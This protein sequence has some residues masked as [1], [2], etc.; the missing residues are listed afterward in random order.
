MRLTFTILLFFFGIQVFAQSV[1]K[2]RIISDKTREPLAYAE[3]LVNN[4]RQI[5]TNIDGSFHFEIAGNS[6]E[7]QVSYIGYQSIKTEVYSA[8]KFV[9]FS[10][11]PNAEMLDEVMIGDEANP[12]NAIIKRAIVARDQNDPEKVL[13]HFQYKSYTKFIIDNENG[14]IQMVSDSTSRNIRTIINEGRGYLSEKVAEH[15]YSKDGGSQEEVIG[16]E[17][18]GFEKPVYN[19][20]SLNI[21]P[22]SLYKNK[23]SL[24][25]TDYAG[26]LANDALRNYSY[27]IL[28]TTKSKRPAYMIYFKPKRHQIVA[29]L[30]GILYLDM[31]TLA[32]QKAKAQ[33]LGAIKLEINH[34]YQYYQ[35]LD[36]WFPS[37]QNT[38]IR[39]G[40]GGKEIAVF[41]GTI[42]VGMVQQKK[43][44][45][46]V[47]SKPKTISN[48]IYLNSSTTNFDI[49]LKPADYFKTH[50]A[51][52]LVANGAA[53]QPEEFWEKNRKEDFTSR[54]QA[55][56]MKVDSLLQAGNVKR[57][58][59]VKNAIATG[60][61]P[62]GF[63][64]ADLSKV[65][66]FNNYEGIRLGFG[67]KTSD[68]V[69]EK[70]NINGYTTYGFKDQVVKYGI[71][72]QVYLKKRTN[73]S[74]NFFYSRDIEETGTFD[75]LK[76]TN[77]FS[78]L[79]PRFV[80]INFFY[81]YKTA[82]ASLKHDII[83]SL[84]TEFRLG[85]QEIWQIKN[86]RYQDDNQIYQD[87]DLGTMTF[88]F[89]WRPF[90][91]FLSTPENT[92]MIE[93]NFPQFTGQIE[94]S[95]K[96][97][98][99]GDFEFTRVGLKA[100]HEINQLDRSRTEFILEGNMAFGDVPLTHAFHSYPNNPNR[101]QIFRRF[102]VAGRNSFETMYFNEFFSDRQA[103]LH[104][105]HQLRPF[106]I[107]EKFQPQ[108]VFIS[109]FAIGNMTNK[110]SHLNIPFNTLDKG[111]SEVGMELNKIFSGFGISTA[112]RYGAY[113]LPTFKENFS[114][115]FTLLL[116]L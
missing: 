67:G 22:F 89:I 101:D 7:V 64:D 1:I 116:E 105:R 80:N 39:P 110:E 97:L 94:H 8:T 29:G 75:Y 81:N 60:Y 106:L 78:I 47:F 4:D 102:S 14:G 82:W 114:L 108:L 65:F 71:G 70:F 33:L 56:K 91:N 95:F 98:F 68:E 10:L 11:K 100:E 28:D 36:L 30:E 96:G 31:K 53:D 26:P 59:E 58:I 15:R 112:Y 35:E 55:T 74:L 66:K 57:K 83:P 87:Y 32:I 99:N 44:V 50:G 77:T 6:A 41:G 3:I 111:Y 63:W 13:Q 109:R 84:S 104:V 27:K 9:Q 52:I 43:G 20:L 73:S 34:T 5:L 79:E 93:R 37:G 103:M 17:T 42:T 18:A 38:T 45:L 54:D 76:G 69:S 16:I 23:Y 62:L 25:K 46:D 51:E 40:S 88:S 48:N 86:Y 113:H 92:K 21:N 72:T 85:K 107:T 2:G 19:L 115:K 12:A 49:Q 90:S 24:Y 61:Y